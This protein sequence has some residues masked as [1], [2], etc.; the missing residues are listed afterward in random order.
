MEI[1][2]VYNLLYIGLGQVLPPNELRKALD[3]QEFWTVIDSTLQIKRM[4]H[5]KIG[6]VQGHI[7]KKW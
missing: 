1:N 6:N 3:S 4:R 7:V 5:L 2:T